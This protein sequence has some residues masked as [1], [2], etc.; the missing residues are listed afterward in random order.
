MN[1]VTTDIQSDILN[2]II[3]SFETIVAEAHSGYKSEGRGAVV[4]DLRHSPHVSGGYLS[5]SRILVEVGP[6]PDD[7]A[8]SHLRTYNPACEVVILARLP[9]ERVLLFKFAYEI[10]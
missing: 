8:G 10:E 2:Y 7:N 3:S 6:L 4:I 9:G 1:Q 5:V